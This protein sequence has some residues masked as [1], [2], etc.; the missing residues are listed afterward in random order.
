MTKNKVADIKIITD[1][2]EQLPYG[3]RTL[4]TIV[5]TLDTG[6]YSLTNHE[7]CISVERKSFPDWIGSITQGRERFERELKRAERFKT[8]YIV[9]E[10]DLKK[11]WKG[12]RYSKANM[13]SVINTSIAYMEKFPHVKV[14]YASTRGQARYLVENLFKFH[15]KYCEEEQ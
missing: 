5:K 7:N 12:T 14:I 10:S 9:I 2:R 15:A 6:D 4:D 11:M 13:T 1:T 3:F 8:F